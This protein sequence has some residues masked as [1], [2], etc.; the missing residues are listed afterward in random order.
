MTVRSLPPV[1]VGIDDTDESLLAVRVGA[2]EA[3]L[4]DRPLHLLSAFAPPPEA[5]PDAPWPPRDAA[6]ARM[7]RAADAVTAA[8]RALD[9]DARMLPGDLVEL[10][11][12]R[13]PHASLVVVARGDLDHHAAQPRDLARGEPG[14]HTAEARAVAGG[15]LEHQGAEARAVARG[16]LEHH[17]AEARALAS[18]D[19]EHHAA[20]ARALAGGDL[21]RHAA[22]ARVYEVAS[23]SAAPVFVVPP[24]PATPGGPVVA[25]LSGGAANDA[26]LEFAF[27]EAA[28]RGVPLRAVHLTHTGPAPLDRFDTIAGLAAPAPPT[29]GFTPADLA[30]RLLAEALAGWPSKYP[31]VQ[32]DRR[33]VHGPDVEHGIA[34]LTHDACMIVAAARGRLETG[35]RILGP[36]TSGL[37]RD[38]QCPV[39]VIPAAD[40]AFTDSCLHG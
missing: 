34:A 33:V 19:L 37:L 20:E 7:M 12:E 3:R 26:L 22:E 5:L 29:I 14:R 39:A 10:L 11:V 1:L 36:I 38:A 23:R 18:G 24:R 2:A 4:R 17:A 6:R 40:H 28:R 8:Y 31:D 15:D 9:L 35:E 13:S 25:G 30:D 32:I 27:D 21:G 16:D